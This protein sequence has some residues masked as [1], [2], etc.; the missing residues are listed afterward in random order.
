MLQAVIS[1][2]K[3]FES[4]APKCRDAVRGAFHQLKELAERQGTCCCHDLHF[5]YRKC[6]AFI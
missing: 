4:I 2:S 5:I 3:D 6:N 1:L